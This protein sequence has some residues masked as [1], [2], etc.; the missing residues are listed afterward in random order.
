MV[1]SPKRTETGSAV[2]FPARDKRPGGLS[3]Y[4]L[5]RE[6]HSIT[7]RDGTAHPYGLRGAVYPEPRL[8]SRAARPLE[9]SLSS[10]S[11]SLT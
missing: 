3:I 9:K 11:N 10:W 2:S 8:K 4:F 7:V 6:G 1:M 5:G